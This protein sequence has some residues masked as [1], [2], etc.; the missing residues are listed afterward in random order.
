MVK[1]IQLH[2][3]Q[4]SSCTLDALLILYSVHSCS[5]CS[6]PLLSKHCRLMLLMRDGTVM[7][8]STGLTLVLDDAILC[9][10]GHHSQPSCQ[11]SNGLAMR[12]LAGQHGLM[13]HFP[14]N[15]GK[16]P[17]LALNRCVSWCKRDNPS[18][19]ISQRYPHNWYVA[20]DVLDYYASPAT[21]SSTVHAL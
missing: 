9:K 6:R 13:H 1:I 5:L 15:W 19:S 2:N 16:T 10:E 12:R 14:W 18:S 21:C 17:W 8:V 11:Q 20:G 7:E 3:V 4:M